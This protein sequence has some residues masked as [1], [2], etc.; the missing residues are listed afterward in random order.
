VKYLATYKIPKEFDVKEYPFEIRNEVARFLNTHAGKYSI[1]DIAKAIKVDELKVAWVLTN[2]CELTTPE[3]I[4]DS[5]KGKEYWEN[6][7]KMKGKSPKS[8]DEK[9]LFFGRVMRK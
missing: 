6:T 3:V 9:V 1:P 4:T 5:I 7:L 2:L 8:F